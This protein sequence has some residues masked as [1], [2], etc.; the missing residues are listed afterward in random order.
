MLVRGFGLCFYPHLVGAG[1]ECAP[2]VMGQAAAGPIVAKPALFGPV[3]VQPYAVLGQSPTV[4]PHGRPDGE[5]RAPGDPSRGADSGYR[6]AARAVAR[7]LAGARAPRRRDPDR[8]PTRTPP[9]IPPTS[10]GHEVTSLRGCRPLLFRHPSR[11][12]EAPVFPFRGVPAA[13]SA[14]HYLHRVGARGELAG[15]E[16]QTAGSPAVLKVPYLL[17]VEVHVDVVLAQGALTVHHGGLHRGPVAA[18]VP[19]RAHRGDGYSPRT[20]P[21][22]TRPGTGSHPGVGSVRCPPSSR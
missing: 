22:R 18:D 9:A 2:Y 8:G 3:E 14:G 20:A 21:A 4:I 1:G 13:R 5:V 6:E 17:P 7:G 16:T 11:D 15:S 19:H 10:S 12:D